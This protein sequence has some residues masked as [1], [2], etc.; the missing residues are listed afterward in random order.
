MK[1]RRLFAGA[2]LTVL[3]GFGTA[4]GQSTITTA[5][6]YLITAKAGGVNE[7]AGDVTVERN[8]GLSGRLLKGDEVQTGERVT[9]GAQSRAE[10]LMNPGS[11]IRIG[12]NTSFEFVSTHLDDVRVKMHSGSA[13][14]EVFGG[15]GFKVDLSADTARFT[16]LDSGIYRIDANGN[17]NS[18]VAVWKG[19]L[20]PAAERETVGG[21]KLVSFNG[22]SYVVTR[23][24]RDDKDELAVWSRNRSK[25]LSKISA[26]LR[27][28]RLRD[29]L[30]NSF[31]GRRWD[32]YNSFGLW[33]Y[34]P[35]F[36]SFCFLPFGDAW[37]PYGFGYGRPLWYYNLPVAIYNQPPPRDWRGSNVKSSSGTVTPSSTAREPGK[38]RSDN[39]NRDV[40]RAIPRGRPAEPQFDPPR[41]Q[42]M[43]LPPLMPQE[44]KHVTRKP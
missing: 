2:L 25:E 22:A 12:E 34:D 24:D 20:R 31:Y 15:E 29:P 32:M 10:I 30:V 7:V 28:D 43:A 3:A 26:S 1:D 21:G 36:R 35:T 23:F 14:L 11:Y 27:P 17:G 4:F 16:I 9:T 38:V 18:M 13:I 5:D 39:S 42:Q 37:S 6:K 41:V 44:T 33:V 40:Y 8:N 19:K